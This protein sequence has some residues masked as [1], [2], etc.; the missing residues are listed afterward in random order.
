MNILFIFGV[1]FLLALG[2]TP[3]IRRVALAYGYVNRP[4]EDRWHQSATPVFGGVGIY[5]ASVLPLLLVLPFDDIITYCPV[6]SM[7]NRPVFLFA[8]MTI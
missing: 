3:L 2:F 7:E 1:A 6:R 4:T 5:F 8:R